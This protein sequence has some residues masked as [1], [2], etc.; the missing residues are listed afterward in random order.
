MP[1]AAK[2]K[3]QPTCRGKKDKYF[4]IFFK[5]HGKNRKYSILSF[6]KTNTF[7]LKYKNEYD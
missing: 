1:A 3:N 7:P 4:F 2:K 6:L 5:I